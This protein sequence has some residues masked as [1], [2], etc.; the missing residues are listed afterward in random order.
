MDKL[1]IAV[2][3]ALGTGLAVLKLLQLLRWTRRE[4]VFLGVPGWGGG[5]TGQALP[6]AFRLASGQEVRT[7]LRH[8]GR[9][10]LPAEGAR[11]WIIHDPDEPGRVEWASAILIVA[12][13]GLALAGV[14]A[15][16]LVRWA[17][18]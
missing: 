6:I 17:Q 14:M 2:A 15:A 1:A 16:T 18:G 11:L 7:T 4:A 12:L 13:I 5:Y 3:C 10:G 9:G 8:Y